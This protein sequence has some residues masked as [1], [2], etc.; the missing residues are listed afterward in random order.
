M[1]VG[2]TIGREST[3]VFDIGIVV[4][5]VRVFELSY[6]K[7]I[8]RLMGKQ[9]KPT[10]KLKRRS[11]RR[12]DGSARSAL[13]SS[14]WSKPIC[15]GQKNLKHRVVSSVNRVPSILLSLSKAAIL[16]SKR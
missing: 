9:K 15:H 7:A 4:I 16:S 12:V 6:L 11:G 8:E 1:I 5:L 10:S 3:V 13:A 2:E 14:W